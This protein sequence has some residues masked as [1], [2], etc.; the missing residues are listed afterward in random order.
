MKVL[1]ILLLISINCI[2][3]NNETF[4]K[5]IKDLSNLEKYIREYIKEKSYTEKSLT[6]LIT[7][8]IRLGAYT[9]SEWSLV[10][11]DIPDDLISYV[12][13]KDKGFRSYVCCYEWH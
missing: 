5:M 10:A 1:L 3:D 7:C 12:K 8:Y 6:H 13:A 2:T 11:G 9:T 4:D